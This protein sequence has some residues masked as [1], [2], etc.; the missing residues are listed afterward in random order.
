MNQTSPMKRRADD[1]ED[2]PLKSRQIKVEN[3]KF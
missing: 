1:S 3:I 2:E